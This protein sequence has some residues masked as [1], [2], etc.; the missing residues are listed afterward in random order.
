M[1]E[2]V[3]ANNKT[4]LEEELVQANQVYENHLKS[5]S[6]KARPE[7]IFFAILAV[8][9]LMMHSFGKTQRL[10]S[11]KHVTFVDSQAE[12]VQQTFKHDWLRTISCT[13]LPMFVTIGA[14]VATG[15]APTPMAV[16]SAIASGCGHGDKLF[17]NSNT[18]DRMKKNH[19]L[20][21]FKM[22][23][24]AE[25]EKHRRNTNQRDTTLQRMQEMERSID[26]AKRYLITAGSGG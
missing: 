24:D 4:W 23:R 15:G 10:M 14:A 7:E 13:V 20:D 22:N 16:A 25:Q 12:K 17:E 18:S 9:T 6:S 26:Q 3:K 11:L 5:P 19:E 21:Q 1:T 8:H 2:P